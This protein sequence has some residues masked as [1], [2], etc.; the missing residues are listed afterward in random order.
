VPPAR[1]V[2][3]FTAPTAVRAI[4]QQDPEGEYV[5]NYDLGELRALFLAGERC[6]PDTL[7]WAQKVLNIP[8]IDHSWQ[9]ETGWAIAANCLWIEAL[10]VVP[11]SPTRAVPGWDLRVLAKDG[12]ELPAGETGALAIKL[13][14]PP[15]AT[16]T[17]WNAEDR[18]RQ[19][20]L[21]QFPG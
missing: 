6:D 12:G 14:M 5:A 19:T 21:S 10:P 9:T 4:R 13:P 2:S 7:N 17:L 8:V 3:L 16:P 18:F 1:V 20:Y 11:G 15:G